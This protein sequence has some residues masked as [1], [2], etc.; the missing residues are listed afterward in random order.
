MIRE[1]KQKLLV[2]MLCLAALLS[3]RLAQANSGLDILKVA[4]VKSGLVVHLGCGDGTLTA[5][6]L[7]NE[8]Y[9]VHGLDTESRNVDS[10]TNVKSRR[11]KSIHWLPRQRRPFAPFLRFG[12]KNENGS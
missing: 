9:L 4:D 7:V 8:R 10:A 3:G 5:D 6:L 11:S 12:I 1:T 2:G